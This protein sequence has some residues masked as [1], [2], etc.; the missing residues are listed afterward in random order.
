MDFQQLTTALLMGE[1]PRSEPFMQGM[2]AVL[3]NRIEKTLVV[4]PYTDGTA[5]ADAFFAGRMRGHSE[6]RNA[7]IEADNNRE[8]AI[9]HLQKL[10]NA[11]R[12]A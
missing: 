2:A 12:V 6:F 9:Q 4:S 10:V 8:R 1:P 11:R 7:L 3:R 5:E